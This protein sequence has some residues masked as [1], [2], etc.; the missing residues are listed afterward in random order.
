MLNLPNQ[1]KEAWENY[2]KLDSTSKWAD[3]A[4]QRLQKL[5]ANKPISKTK[6]EVLQDFLEAKRAND[7]EKAWQ[8]LSRNREMITGKLIPQQLAFLFVDSKTSG[9]EAT[10]KE[11]LDALIYAGKLEEKKSGD[12]FWRDLAEYYVNVSDEKISDL[13]KAQDTIREGYKLRKDGYLD[14]FNKT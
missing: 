2:L 5:E 13:K 1:A 12:L 11:T 4:R 9:D 6:E 10:A 7:T 8:T 14:Y 3:E